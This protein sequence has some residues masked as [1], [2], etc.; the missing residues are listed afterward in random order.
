MKAAELRQMTIADLKAQL[1]ELKDELANLRIQKA[2]HQIQNPNRI[3]EVKRDIAR[4]KTILREYEL[5]ISK[6]LEETK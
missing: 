2:M 3:R 1:E 5:G 6:P 4:I